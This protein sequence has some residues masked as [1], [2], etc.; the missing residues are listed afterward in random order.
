[1]TGV[2]S[3]S[4]AA[5]LLEGHL[6]GADGHDRVALLDQPVEVQRGAADSGVVL[7]LAVERLLAP[8]RAVAVQHPHDVVGEAGQDRLVVGAP[9]ALDVRLHDRLVRCQA[10]APLTRRSAYPHR[11]R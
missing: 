4:D 7:D 2:R 3:R 5:G 11:L 1:V 10:P 6:A 9:E 8:Q